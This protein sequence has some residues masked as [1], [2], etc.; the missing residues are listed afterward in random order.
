M[1]E[2]FVREHFHRES[3]SIYLIHEERFLFGGM[4]SLLWLVFLRVNL[5]LLSYLKSIGNWQST[6]VLV[7]KSEFSV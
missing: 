3:D 1:A 5:K 7:H 2:H 6:N 4:I